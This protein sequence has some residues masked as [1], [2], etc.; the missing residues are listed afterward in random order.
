MVEG[1]LVDIEC[2]I[3]CSIADLKF[4]VFEPVR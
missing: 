1:G 2:L 4:L 3:R